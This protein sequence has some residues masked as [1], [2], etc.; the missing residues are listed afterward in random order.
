MKKLTVALTIALGL[1]LL[2]QPT[3]ADNSSSN[4]RSQSEQ[5]NKEDGSPSESVGSRSQYGGHTHF[6]SHGKADGTY[7][8]I[9]G[10]SI[11]PAS[12]SG[13]I[14]Y[15]GGPVLQTVNLYKIYYGNWSTPCASVDTSTAGVLNNFLN[16]VGSSSWYKTTTSYY[17][18]AGSAKSF[19]SNTV[20]NTG[21]IS[22][23][24][25]TLGTSFNAATGNQIYTI[26][27]NQITAQSWPANSND[28]YFVFTSPDISVSGFKTSM[29]GYHSYTNSGANTVQYSFVG[30]SGNSASCVSSSILSASPNANPTADGM[31]SVVAHELVETVSD[32]RLNAWFDGAGYEN[33][34]KC[35]WIFGSTYIANLAKANAVSGVGNYFLQENVAANTN[36]CVSVNPSNLSTFGTLSSSSGTVGSTLSLPG[37]GFS[38]AQVIFSGTYSITVKNKTTTYQ[39]A[40][41]TSVTSTSTLIT[42]TVPTGATT[43]PITVVTDYG[44]W[45]SPTNFNVTL[46]ALSTISSIT[47]STGRIG[48][49]ISI[50]GSNFTGATA[51]KIGTVSMTGFTVV[52]DSLITATIPTTAKTGSITVTG[53]GGTSTGVSFT[54]AAPVVSSFTPSNSL[55]STAITITGSNF[56]GATGA[57]IGTVAL[58]GFSVVNDTQINA[59]IPTSATTATISVTSAAGTGTSTGLFVKGLPTITGFTPASITISSATNSVTITGTNLLGSTLVTLINTSGIPIAEISGLTG[60]SATKATFLCP[61]TLPL[62]TYKIHITTPAGISAESASSLTIK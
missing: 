44:V 25:S 22:V 62:T 42:A 3:F 17:S 34:D 6:D 49:P 35:A 57:K 15:H 60:V 47:P 8:P 1:T 51:V 43:G 38:G 9:I 39:F 21:C 7:F 52:S 55:A 18:V 53:P 11:Q 45:V 10:A 50:N 46:P 5:T 30:D 37:T 56:T 41:A 13:N 12:G 32:P 23:P 29:C 48:T 27:Q 28:L 16:T 61:K 14:V 33:G 4:S 54:V 40:P 26:V 58:T 19:V 36:S 59:T 20:N 2:Q 24:S 31:A